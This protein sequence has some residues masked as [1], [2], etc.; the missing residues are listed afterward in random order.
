MVSIPQ[1]TDVTDARGIVI[2]ALVI[3]GLAILALA[4]VIVA[5]LG[6]WLVSRARFNE[7]KADRDQRYDEY[8]ADRD[9][10]RNWS[11][12]QDGTIKEMGE[13]NKELWARLQDR[14]K[15]E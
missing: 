2:F 12:R 10:W 14:T 6:E 15:H 7:M 11:L 8:K 4:A 9:S 5:I 1:Q 3:S 13:T